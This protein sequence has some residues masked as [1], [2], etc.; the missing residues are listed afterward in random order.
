MTS[1]AL[2][3]TWRRLRNTLQ[4]NAAPMKTT[5]TEAVTASGTWRCSSMESSMITAS[6]PI[7]QC[8]PCSSYT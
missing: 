2:A 4:P 1:Q 7:A 8:A 5:P 6:A 3:G